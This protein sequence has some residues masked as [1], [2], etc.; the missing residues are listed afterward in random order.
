MCIP[1]CKHIKDKYRWLDKIRRVQETKIIIYKQKT[2]KQKIGPNLGPIPSV[3]KG[4][5]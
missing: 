5:H 4:S 2:N 3:W 1:V